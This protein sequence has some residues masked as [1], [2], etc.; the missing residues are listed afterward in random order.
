MSLG[1]P[2]A[3]AGA[4]QVPR[5]VER[6]AGVDVLKGLVEARLVVEAVLVK[7]VA[8]GERAAGKGA[9]GQRGK[10]AKRGGNVSVGMAVR[11]ATWLGREGRRSWWVGG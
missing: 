4:H 3:G 7:V 5:D 9:K 2:G 10:E 1:H 11:C 8:Q 6:L